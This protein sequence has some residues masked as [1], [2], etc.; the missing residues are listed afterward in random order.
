MIHTSSRSGINYICNHVILLQFFHDRKYYSSLFRLPKHISTGIN[1]LKLVFQQVNVAVSFYTCIWKAPPVSTHQLRFRSYREFSISSVCAG[2]TPP[3]K[4]RPPPYYLPHAYSNNQ[5][6]RYRD[7][8]FLWPQLL[9]RPL[10]EVS[11]VAKWR[12]EIGIQLRECY[13]QYEVVNS[14]TFIRGKNVAM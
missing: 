11:P 10:G 9:H 4:V 3:N 6:A 5:L 7:L 8:R 12:S 2:M 1:L 14:C 13:C